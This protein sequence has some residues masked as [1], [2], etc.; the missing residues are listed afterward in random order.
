MDGDE[1]D[2]EHGDEDGEDELLALS[3]FDVEHLD[4]LL[5]DTLDDF[6]SGS[7]D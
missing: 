1:K 6:L 5:F 2:E 3:E 7:D 4:D